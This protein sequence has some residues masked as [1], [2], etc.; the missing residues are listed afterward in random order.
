MLAAHLGIRYLR[1]RRA[2]WLALAAVI[3][4][5]AVPI[6]VLGVMQGIVD[7]TRT[8]VRASESDLTVQPAGR[9]IG[10]AADGG[11]HAALAAI[12][13]VRGV[14]PFIGGV[15]F[16]NSRAEGSR[17]DARNNHF[18]TIDG[19]DWNQDWA[20]GR[21]HKGLLHQRPVTELSDPPLRPDERGS[22]FLTPD[23]RH[24]MVLS[25]WNIAADLGAMPLPPPP[26]QRPLPGI[27]LG[28]ELIYGVGG[29]APWSPLRPGS[30]VSMIIPDGRGGTIGRVLAEV[31]DTIAVGALEIDRFASVLPLPLAQRLT[32]MDGR[33]PD[34][35]GHSEI[36]G[37]R[38]MLDP[39]ASVEDVRQRIE[40]GFPLWAQT[41]QER[42]GNLVRSLE[43]QRN[44]L[45]LVMIL[46]QGICIFI[47]Y[48]VFSTLVAEKRHDIGVLLGLG[49]APGSIAGAFILAGQSACVIGGVIGWAL[50]WFAL[51]SLNPLSE[52][53][54]VPLFP[55][56]VFYSPEAPISW[57]ARL[58]LLFVGVIML[59]GLAASALPA[60]RAARIDPVSTLR[61]HG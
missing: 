9:R 58:P 6:V 13:G 11:E 38:I 29:M 59:V 22:G 40:T 25:G 49:A 2:A 32:A 21:L 60:W 33:H 19:I 4:S 34:S 1:K 61:E 39:R 26:S 35:N 7:A 12:P 30:Q 37:Y 57:D 8:Q 54:G 56:A 24:H 18:T 55:Q 16:I 14:S 47:I 43:V 15:A 28:R 31:S 53:L 45:L 52:W 17:A 3:L 46:I 51:A 44:I 50:G 41:W 20:A 5:V 48:A 42:R 23:W 10:M 27:I 36:S